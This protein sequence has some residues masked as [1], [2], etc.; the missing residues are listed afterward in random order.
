MMRT[1]TWIFIGLLMLTVINTGHSTEISIIAVGDI[2]IGKELTLT[3]E[4]QGIDK[5]FARTVEVFKGADITVGTLESSISAGGEAMLGIKNPVRAVPAAARGLANAGFK[6][7]SLATPHIM[8][9]G[10]EA[11]HDTIELL[12]WYAV[13]SVGAG[14]NREAAKKPV[15]LTVK[16][17][18]ISFLAYYQVNQFAQNLADTYS[19][20]PMPAIPSIV[21]KDIA[22]VKKEADIVVV[23]VHWGMGGDELTEKQRFWTHNIIDFGA[24]LVLGQRLHALQGIEIYNDKAIVYSLADFIFELKDKQHAKIVIPKFYFRDGKLK[25]IELIPIWV[26]NPEAKYQPQLLRGR[27]AKRTLEKFKQLCASYN[28]TVEIEDEKGCIKMDY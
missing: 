12:S 6:V 7:L 15:I 19:P 11:L 1:L 26:D 8:D 27:E 22:E 9:Y 10:W 16:E 14:E 3:I 4:Q 2:T 20:G 18:K 28:T 25:Q 5:L 24:D 23:F 21:K 17:T 13:K